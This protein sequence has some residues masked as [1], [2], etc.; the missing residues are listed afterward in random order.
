MKGSNGSALEFVFVDLSSPVILL[1][2][3]IKAQV[4]KVFNSETILNSFTCI[5]EFKSLI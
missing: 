3:A 4:S 5:S 2:D 1:R